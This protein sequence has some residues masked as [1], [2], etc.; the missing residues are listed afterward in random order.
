MR[1]T[2]DSKDAE[3]PADF[4]DAPKL[5]FLPIPIE[6]PPMIRTSYLCLPVA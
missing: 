1:S 2:Y 4:G 6:V 5:G 3:L